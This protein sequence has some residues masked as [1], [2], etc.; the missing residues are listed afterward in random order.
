[1]QYWLFVALF[2]LLAKGEFLDKTCWSIVGMGVFFIAVCIFV[3]LGPSK[4]ELDTHGVYDH[5]EYL[6]SS[7]LDNGTTVFHFTNGSTWVA[8]G[9]HQMN[10]EF[11]VCYK[12]Y[13]NRG[14]G[15][16]GTKVYECEDESH[17]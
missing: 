8:N 17:D 3:L 13:K 14:C 15:T 16:G 5:V 4:Y 1:M 2:L 12:V 11:G 10:F 6:P 7:F 9:H